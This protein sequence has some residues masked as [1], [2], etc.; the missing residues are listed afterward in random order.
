MQHFTGT[1]VLEELGFDHSR[2]RGPLAARSR[3][4]YG[5]LWLVETDY[6]KAWIR[7]SNIVF[8]RGVDSIFWWKR[9]QV[10]RDDT[11]PFIARH[12]PDGFR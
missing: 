5:S 2:C 12:R 10:R 8:S 3:L 9:K 7:P 1:R 4:L 11:F 6:F